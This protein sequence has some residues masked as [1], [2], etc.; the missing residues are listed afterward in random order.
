MLFPFSDVTNISRASSDLVVRL[1][2]YNP[3][4]EINLLYEGIDQYFGIRGDKGIES[5][6]S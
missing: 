1:E 5:P 6:V 2:D 4:Q 3:G